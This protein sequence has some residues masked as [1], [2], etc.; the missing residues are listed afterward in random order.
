MA[1]LTQFGFVGRDF[2][3]GAASFCN[4]ASQMRYKHPRCAQSDT[5]TILF[6]PSLER[7]LFYVDLLAHFH[8]VM[9]QLAVQTLAMGCQ[10]ALCLSMVSAGLLIPFALFPREMFFALFLDTAFLIVVLRVIRTSL[11]LHLALH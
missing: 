6:L 7:G 5:A 9:G 11:P 3:Q 4:Y 8:D 10:F 2:D 1:I